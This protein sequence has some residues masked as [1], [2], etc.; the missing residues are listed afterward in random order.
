MTNNL[1]KDIYSNSTEHDAKVLLEMAR[2][3]KARNRFL[4][5][6]QYTM[7]NYQVNWHHK[8]ICD[9]ID[10]FLINPDRRYLMLFTPP[11]KGKSEIIARKLPAYYFGKHPDKKIIQAAYGDSL[12]SGFNL[13]VQRTMDSPEY[14]KIFPNTLIPSE[15]RSVKK[16]RGYV[17]N[18]KEFNIL[19]NIG[20]YLSAGVDGPMTGEGFHLGLIDDPIKN[21]AEA[22]STARNKR[23]WNWWETTFITR[24]MTGHK[25]ILVMTRWAEKDLAGRLIEEAEK[26]SAARQWEII[27]FPEFYDPDHPWLHP[28]DPRTEPGQVIWEEAYPESEMIAAKASSSAKTWASL[29]QQLPTPDEGVIFK[30]EQFQFFEETPELHFTVL[31]IDCA[32]KDADTSDYVAFTI[33]GV[34]GPNKYLTYAEK[35]RLDFPK[36]IKKILQLLQKFPTL[37]MVLVEDKANGPAVISTLKNKVSR[38]I[39][40]NPQGSK[41]ARANAV[42]PQVEG[43]NVFLPDPYYPPNRI[44]YPWCVEGVDSFIE[45][46]CAFPYAANDD[47]VDSMTQALLKIGEKANW[48]EEWLTNNEENNQTSKSEEFTQDL[49]EMMGW[50]I[51]H[52]D[53]PFADVFKKMG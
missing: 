24:A 8:I 43:G 1:W 10:D 5:F 32:F 16:K 46:V 14:R 27:C 20:S 26:N 15:D 51:D 31:S 11:R 21:A 42:S 52:G 28:D 33:W 6:I 13:A 50:D 4:N 37:R 9:E 39:A 45:E 53:I 7:P 17:R 18:S 25:V 48:M 23:I 3:G 19:D 2:L 41:V 40:F 36:T 44:R 38:L 12:A 29:Y 47:F 22:Y 34:N 49:A 35:D 30:R